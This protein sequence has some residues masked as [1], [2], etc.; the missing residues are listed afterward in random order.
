MAAIE[1]THGIAMAAAHD[2]ATRRMRDENR[3]SWNEED[4]NVAAEHA[5]YLAVCGGLIPEEAYEQLT[6]QSFAARVRRNSR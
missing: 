5:A 3:D 2:R 4:F 1:I 6:G